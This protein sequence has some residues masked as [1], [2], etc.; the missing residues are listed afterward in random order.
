MAAGASNLEVVVAKLKKDTSKAE[1]ERNGAVD[2]KFQ[3]GVNFQ[4]F[5]VDINLFTKVVG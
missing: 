4:M 5:A 2:T 3:L 1:S